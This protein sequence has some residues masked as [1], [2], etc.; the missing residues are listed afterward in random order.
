[1]Q[2]GNLKLNGTYRDYGI[3]SNFDFLPLRL[4]NKLLSFSACSD[5]EVSKARIL[6]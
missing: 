4:K 3:L 2:A 5:F 6:G 1:M